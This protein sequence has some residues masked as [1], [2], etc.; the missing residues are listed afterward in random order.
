MNRNDYA[1]NL[2]FKIGTPTHLWNKVMTEVHDQ[3]VAGPFKE[4]PLKHFVQSP[5]ELVPKSGGKKMRMIFHLSYNFG[6]EWN[7]KSINF[8]TPQ[9]LC[10]VKY[11]DIDHA[12]KNYLHLLNTAQDGQTLTYAKTNCSNAFRLVPT[13]IAQHCLLCMQVTHPITHQVMYFINKCLLFGS[14][15][16][17]ALFQ[18]FSHALRRIAEHKIFG[19]SN[20]ISTT[21]YKLP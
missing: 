4:L 2:P 17:C 14:S 3:R 1:K 13:L 21:N 20:C 12:V 19:N 18:V 16:S 6:S 15:H 11:N 9:E 7:R 8:H 10:T 5:L